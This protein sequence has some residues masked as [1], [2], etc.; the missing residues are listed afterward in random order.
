MK[1]NGKVK[2]VA[3]IGAVLFL[4]AVCVLYYSTG[5]IGPPSGFLP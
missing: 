5:N 2:V 3:G 1:R 4:L